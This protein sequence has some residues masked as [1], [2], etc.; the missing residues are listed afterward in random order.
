LRVNPTT[1]AVVAPAAGDWAETTVFFGRNTN[2]VAPTV[3]V[4][5]DAKTVKITVLGTAETTASPMLSVVLE[6]PLKLTV[7]PT[8][9]LCAVPEVTV[10]VVAVVA[11]VVAVISDENWTK[12]GV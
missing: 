5:P 7:S 3:P 12:P 4:Q 8:D 11:T 2:A 9:R 1:V 6:E 10:R